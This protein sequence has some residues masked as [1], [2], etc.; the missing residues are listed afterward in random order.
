MGFSIF[1][2]I[3]SSILALVGGFPYLRDIHNKRTRPHIL[4][5]IGWSFVTGLGASAILAEVSTWVAGLLI[6]NSI[7]CLTVAIYSAV[8]KVGVWSASKYDYILFGLGIL[9]LVLWMIFDM[10]IIALICSIIAD[11]SFG[12]PTIIKTY[13]DPSSETPFIWVTA[14]L[15]ALLSL[16][17]IESISFNEVAF[18]SYLFMFDSTVLF[19]ALRGRVRRP[20][21]DT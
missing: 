10:P 11:F 12:I 2:G 18:S 21:I 8:K 5:W 6:A 7:L 13:K 17:A 20:S 14:V 15:S 16:F 3:T 19:L 1:F 4:S 9:G